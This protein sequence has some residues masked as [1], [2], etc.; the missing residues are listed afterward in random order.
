MGAREA[1]IYPARVGAPRRLICARAM[2]G[3]VKPVK[4]SHDG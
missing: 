2:D 4:P 1:A 3:R